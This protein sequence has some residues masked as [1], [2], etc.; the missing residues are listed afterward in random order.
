VLR[1]LGGA[2]SNRVWT[3]G[4]GFVAALG[5]GLCAIPGFDALNYF[6]SLATALGGS[7]VAC[8]V[9]AR[10]TRRGVAAG[11][12]PRALLVRGAIAAL[13]L[14]LIPLALLAANA[15][16]VKN[17]DMLE[18]LAFYAV[19]PVASFLF[20]AMLGAFAGL[21][22]RWAALLG[23]LAWLGWCLRDLA[24]FYLEPPVFC[25]NPF[26][27]FV[28][29]ALYDDV[30]QIDA[31]YGWFRLS[32]L[33]AVLVL[34]QIAR[35]GFDPQAGR[36][37]WRLLG[38]VRLRSWGLLATGALAWGVL[39]GVRGTLGYEITR[40]FVHASLGGRVQGD[41]LVVYY[42]QAHLDPLEAS[43][44]FEDAE[45]RLEQLDQV[46]GHRHPERIGIYVYGSPA[47]K[48]A[49]MGA[50][51][52][53]I[54]KP[55]QGEVHLNRFSYGDAVLQ[56]ELAHVVLGAFG[57]APFRLPAAWVLFPHVA[58]VE[59]SAVA[60]ER[61]SEELTLHQW[62][63]AMKRAGILPPIADL[64]GPDGFY[65]QAAG[66]A[67]TASGSFMRYLLERHGARPFARAYRD[68]D[69][70]TAYEVPLSAL[71]AD[72]EAFL[73]RVE[74]PRHA[75]MLAQERF[76]RPGVLHGMCPLVIPRFEAEAARLLALGQFEAAAEVTRRVVG[77]WPEHPPKRVLLVD[78]LSRVPD[79]TRAAQEVE[80]A[81]Q[82]TKPGPAIRARLQE[83]LAD[84]RWRSGD[85]DAAAKGYLALVDEPATQ[86]VRRNLL[87][88]LTVV[89]DA[90]REP[91]LGPYLLGRGDDAIA[92][93]LDAT[94]DLPNDPLLTY[95]LGRRYALEGHPA[96]AVAALDHALEG[97]DRDTSPP[98][99]ML[100]RES[101]RLLG[102]SL[103]QLG[104]YPR[105]EVAF[106]TARLLA[107]AAGPRET[108]AD[109]AARAR[110][111][112]SRR[113]AQRAVFFD[114]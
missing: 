23:F 35:M 81:L 6:S 8:L 105:A 71:S 85:L 70:E 54:A 39:Y 75:E 3:L 78:A 4:A 26:A 45:Y 114:R 44:V 29:G 84:A 28:S 53:H 51:K 10:L 110:W 65:A 47:R 1:E 89:R 97:L 37:R 7:L 42:D 67:Y 83:L 64:M 103:L 93:L 91:I 18:G 63:A 109:W 24:F 62:S 76:D 5:F 31:R 32:N 99:P 25:F 36:V 30:V 113:L 96:E 77:F 74:L 55:W 101:W 9:A 17:C 104:Q 88:K 112:G 15:L 86:D 80:A 66:K 59:G 69:F 41:R 95:L 34:V 106:E 72:W 52:V 20:A 49:L 21:V 43:R 16:R 48:H 107:E 92:Y 13:A 33:V 100:A 38:S 2:L 22:T 94:V 61:P 57:E 82:E 58:V 111:L 102:S 50:R 56:H 68:A 108:M 60:L 11:E 87:V 14:A 46:L 79:P 12:Q 98:A 73:D 19:G 27:G 40:D 90:D